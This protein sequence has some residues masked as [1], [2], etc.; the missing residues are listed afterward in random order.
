MSNE[1]GEELTESHLEYIGALELLSLV[2]RERASFTLCQRFYYLLSFT[3]K[4][5]LG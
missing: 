1:N 3:K 5:S 4:A 2:V